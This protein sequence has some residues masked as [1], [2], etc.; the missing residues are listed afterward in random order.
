MFGDFI[1]VVTLT[2]FFGAVLIG[3]ILSV[4]V[5]E[6]CHALVAYWGGDRSV[7]ERGYLSLNPLTYIDPFTSILLPCIFL[8]MG[9]VPLPGGAVMIDRSSLRSRFWESAVAAAGPLANILLFIVIAAILHVTGWADRA[10]TAE[11]PMW[12]R[13]LGVLAVLQVFATLINLLPIPP[14]DGFGIIE[15]FFDHETRMRFSQPQF[16]SMG[17]FVLVIL[18]FSSGMME[19]F[20]QIIDVVMTWCDLPFELTW[21]NFNIAFFGSSG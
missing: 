2:P 10:L 19:K 15:P 3:W 13:L 11:Q 21:R 12:V 16:R 5:H 7:R 4:S 6:F 14:L 1:A 8:F 20:Q 18:F 17:F 9:G